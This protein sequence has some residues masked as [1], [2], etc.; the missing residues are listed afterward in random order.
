MIRSSAP[1]G[2]DEARHF[3]SMCGPKF[4]SMAITRQVRDLAA[5]LAEKKTAWRR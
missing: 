1:V 4:Y 5:M 3:C 2:I